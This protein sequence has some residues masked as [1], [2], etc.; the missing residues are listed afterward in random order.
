LLQVDR[1]YTVPSKKF[2]ETD[3]DRV[4]VYACI[5]WFYSFTNHIETK[6]EEDYSIA[7]FQQWIANSTEVSLSLKTFTQTY[8]EKDFKPLVL[9]KL[10]RCHFQ[11]IYSG[12]LAANSFTESENAALKK[13]NMGPRPN[14][15]IDRSHE[16]ICVGQTSLG[17]TDPGIQAPCCIRLGYLEKV[18]KTHFLLL[19]I[20]RISSH[21][22]VPIQVFS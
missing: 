15:S 3:N 17:T 11:D 19:L 2:I 8:W 10:C 5:N 13:D 12:D 14:Q 7:S 20:G 4:F 21:S 16:A 22:I 18:R 9:P 1:N 6:L